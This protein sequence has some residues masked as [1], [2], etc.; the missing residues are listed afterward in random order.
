MESIE[1]PEALDLL[2]FFGTEP[3]IDSD[4]RIYNVRDSLDNEL[5][6]SYDPYADWVK[7]QLRQNGCC[8]VSVC[9]EG[10]TQM[11]VVESALTA[12]F[13][14]SDFKISL[15]LILQPNIRVEWSGLI[16]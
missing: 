6:F 8:I 16:V 15:R 7:T 5:A 13:L 9:N 12:E 3:V 2:D 11:D 14:R 10:L 4:V 1:Y